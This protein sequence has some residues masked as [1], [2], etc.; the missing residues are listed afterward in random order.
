MNDIRALIQNLMHQL[1][2]L[3]AHQ[4]TGDFVTFTRPEGQGKTKQFEESLRLDEVSIRIV[5]ILIGSLLLCCD[6]IEPF[7]PSASVYIS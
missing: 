1:T 4:V 5:T 2:D 6:V 7:C 3:F